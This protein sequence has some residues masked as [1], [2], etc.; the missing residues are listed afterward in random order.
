MKLY[1]NQSFDS[2]N[3]KIKLI[4]ALTWLLVAEL[5]EINEK[6][7]FDISLFCKKDFSRGKVLVLQ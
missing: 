2:Q 5:Y 3:T 6:T 4:W 1:F 7:L